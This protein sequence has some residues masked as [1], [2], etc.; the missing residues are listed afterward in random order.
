MFLASLNTKKGV[1]TISFNEKRN[2]SARKKKKKGFTK[3]KDP[4]EQIVKIRAETEICAK[5][6]FEIAHFFWE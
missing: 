6:F 4:S 2:M 5:K 1:S 3:E